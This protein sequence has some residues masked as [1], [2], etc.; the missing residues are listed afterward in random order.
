MSFVRHLPIGSALHR[1]LEPEQALWSDGAR[2]ADILADIFDLLQSFKGTF[3]N[4]H[5]KKKAKIV[6]PYPRPW[7]KKKTQHFGKDP[8]PM[9]DFDKWWRGGK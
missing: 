4:A 8:I 6:D 5:S 3:V 9:A 1:E 7:L 2:L